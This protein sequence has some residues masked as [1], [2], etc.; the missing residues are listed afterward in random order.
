MSRMVKAMLA[1]TLFAIATWAFLYPQPMLSPGKLIAGHEKL[2]ADCF[3]CHAALRG[4]QSERCLAC[5][6]LAD[7]GRVT[8]TGIAI[9][10]PTP[11]HQKLLKKDCMAC[12]SDH[13]GVKR[14]RPQGRFS[15]ALLQPATRQ[16][17]QSCHRSPDDSLH[18]KISGNCSRCHSQERWTPASF[19]HGKYFLLDR[20]HDVRCVTCHTGNDYGR[21]TCY[22]CHAHSPA[23]IRREHVEEGI[24][25][26]ENCVEC[27]RS[28]NAHDIRGAHGEARREDD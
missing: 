21:Y 13:A 9:A 27:H 16:Q 17:C 4:A 14:F 3:A 7:I 23:G 19:D 26:F 2:E 10:N 5:H 1:I 20:D 24:R 15:H 18:R 28:A 8:T 11:F 12:H 25:D 22:G 6:P